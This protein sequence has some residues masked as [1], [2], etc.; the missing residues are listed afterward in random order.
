M[1]KNVYEII[2]KLKKYAES[3][4]KNYTHSVDL[5]MKNSGLII[6]CDEKKKCFEEFYLKN[7]KSLLFIYGAAGTGKSTMINYISSLFKR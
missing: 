4:I 3:G 2:Y 5:W 6:D 7:S 1:T